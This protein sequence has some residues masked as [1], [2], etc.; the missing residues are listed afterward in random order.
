MASS[1]GIDPVTGEW[2]PVFEGQRP[3][4][5]QGHSIRETHGA[6]LSPAK[7]SDE[8][9][10]LAAELAP[11]VPGYSAN[12]SV[13]TELLALALRRIARAEPAIAAV[14]ER[15]ELDAGERLRR[16]QRSW[17]NSATRLLDLLGMVPASRAKLGLDVARMRSELDGLADAGRAIRLAAVE[18]A[19]K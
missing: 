19:R 4:F 17:L 7:L 2:K 16:E 6:Y 3:P 8:T 11:L 13:A 5:E 12:D 9:Q 18:E 1:S 14:E 10:A 15:G